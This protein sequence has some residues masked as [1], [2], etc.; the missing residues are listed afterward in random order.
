MFT[1][2]FVTSGTGCSMVGDEVINRANNDQEITT[3]LTNCMVT[4]VTLHV[5]YQNPYWVYLT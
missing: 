3:G 4:L 1:F 2:Y 5:M